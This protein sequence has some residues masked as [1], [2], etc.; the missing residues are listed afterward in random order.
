MPPRRIFTLILATLGIAASAAGQPAKDTLSYELVS[1]TIS[2]RRR[3]WASLSSSSAR[4][5]PSG[6]STSAIR[7]CRPDGVGDRDTR[8]GEPREYPDRPGDRGV[9]CHGPGVEPNSRSE[10]RDAAEPYDTPNTGAA[11][12]RELSRSDRRGAQETGGLCDLRTGQGEGRC[13]HLLQRTR[14]RDEWFEAGVLD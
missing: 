2:Q 7:P 3:V 5:S 10:S 4:A 13:R 9:R 11:A 12:R 14:G 1:A 8:T 6:I